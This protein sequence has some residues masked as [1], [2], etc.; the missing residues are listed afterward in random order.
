MPIPDYTDAD[1]AERFQDHLPTGAI[2][3]RDDDAVWS[4]LSL[5]LM[6]QY[7]VLHQRSVNLLTDAFPVAPVELLPEWELTLGLPD[8]CAGESPTVAL[9]QAQVAARFVASGGQSAPYFINVAAELGYAITITEFT[10]SRFG[11][12]FGSRF[13]GAAWAD[14]WQINAPT[15]T[16]TSF[17]FGSGRFG[18][19]FREW[20]NTVLQCEL[21]RIKPAHTVLIFNYS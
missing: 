8:P 13:Y 6:H 4:Q 2:W 12:P 14:T 11:Q 5:A 3:P 21:N 15:Y 16:I 20:G 10:V 17:R 18:D 19:R 1:F 7:T 9:R